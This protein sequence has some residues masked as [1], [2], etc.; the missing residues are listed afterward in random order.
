MNTVSS[1]T[2]YDNGSITKN[3]AMNRGGGKP[4]SIEL[5]IEKSALC[6]DTMLEDHGSNTASGASISRC[7]KA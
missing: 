6:K 4:S 7:D 3:N 5:A 2:K 1:R